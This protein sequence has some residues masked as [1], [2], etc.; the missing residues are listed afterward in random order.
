LA[1]DRHGV[2][3]AQSHVPSEN[4]GHN[5]SAN[6]STRSTPIAQRSHSSITPPLGGAV[7]G[8]Q[9]VGGAWDLRLHQPSTPAGHHVGPGPPGSPDVGPVYSRGRGD[10]QGGPEW[11][12]M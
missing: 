10:R 5:A 3:V 4:L 11:A 6:E 1:A 9:A 7:H 12:G 2:A 8:R